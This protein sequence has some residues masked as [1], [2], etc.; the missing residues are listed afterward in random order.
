MLARIEILALCTGNI[1]RSPMAVGFLRQR[2]ADRALEATITSAGL[3]TQ[4]QPASNPAVEVLAQRGIDLRAHSSRKLAA[5]H[6]AEADLVLAM[7]RR[8]LREA[9]V[10]HPSAFPKTYTIKELVR[11]GDEV[12]GRLVGERLDE[13]LARLHEGRTARD[14]MGDDEADDVRDPIG[15]PLAVYEDVAAEL[16]D[17]VDRVVDLIW[18]PDLAEE[19]PA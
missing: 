19:I 17:L 14:H 6:V 18:G 9:V 12:G 16:E 1:C 4:G 11:R 5:Q 7:A 13:W 8:H 15:E 3:I 2:L 10:L